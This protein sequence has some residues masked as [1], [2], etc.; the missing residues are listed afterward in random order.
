M[1]ASPMHL[2]AALGTGGLLA[3]MV[4]LNGTLAA[5]GSLLFASWVPHATGTLAALLFLLLLRPA[6]AETGRPPLWAYLGGIFGAV[7]VMLTSY[8]VNTTLALSG[9]IAIGLAGQ[10]AFA[11][12]ADVKG[13]F[14]LPVRRPTARDLFALGLILAGSLVLIFASAA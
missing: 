8:T 9:T 3:V 5:H 2:A 6:R 1:G 12:V 14:G 10:V 7:T 4:L 13:L 11:L